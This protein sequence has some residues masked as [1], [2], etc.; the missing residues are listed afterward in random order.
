MDGL[1]ALLIT[2]FVTVGF[3]LA[4][5]GYGHDSRPISPEG[6]RS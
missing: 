2:L 3:G 1:L 4:A 6:D 5:A